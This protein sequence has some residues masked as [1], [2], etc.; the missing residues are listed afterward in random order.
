MD[1]SCD[2]H[3]YGELLDNFEHEEDDMLLLD[4]MDD[5]ELNTSMGLWTLP[6]PENHCPIRE[7]IIT[8]PVEESL[9]RPLIENHLLQ[10]CMYSAIMTGMGA[11]RLS[12][13]LR[14]HCPSLIQYS[15]VLNAT[16]VHLRFW[17]PTNK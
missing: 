1:D 11:L 13:K 9:L 3:E 12:S 4:A 10:K 8:D 6:T 2:D 5:A 16:E 7:G 17:W 14:F 15:F